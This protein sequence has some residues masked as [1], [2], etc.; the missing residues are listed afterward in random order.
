M[1]LDKIE[2]LKKRR[3][4]GKGHRCIRG[5]WHTGAEH[6]VISLLSVTSY[7]PLHLQSN[8]AEGTK[9]MEQKQCKNGIRD[10]CSTADIFNGCS[11]GLLV[12]TQAVT[13][14]KQ[15]TTY[16]HNSPIS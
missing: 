6:A 15:N 5:Y 9:T 12:V 3:E 13:Q 10:A 14:A 7:L 11:S 16:N 4:K 2:Y 1:A 8:N